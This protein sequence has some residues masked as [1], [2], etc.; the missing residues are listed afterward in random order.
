MEKCVEMKKI[1]IK[2]ENEYIEEI[3]K[4]MK[5]KNAELIDLVSDKCPSSINET[6]RVPIIN[7]RTASWVLNLPNDPFEPEKEIPQKV[8]SIVS[9]KDPLEPEK[10]ILPQ[11][12]RTISSK[13][14]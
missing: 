5:M 1:E 3:N 10:E 8:S 13:D 4:S 14:P 12:N 11:V 9:S 6:S 7:T 2:D